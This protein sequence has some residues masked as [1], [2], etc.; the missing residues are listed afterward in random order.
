VYVDD[1]TS[2]LL[3]LRFARTESTFDYFAVTERYLKRYGK[4]VAFYSDKAS[5]FRV[6]AKEAIAGV[7]YTQFGRAASKR[8]ARISGQVGSRRPATSTVRSVARRSCSA[9]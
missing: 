7:G 4:P 5:I 2:K 6:K 1:A 3:E 9:R 8:R